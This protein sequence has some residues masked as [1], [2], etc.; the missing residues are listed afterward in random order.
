[1]K[2]KLF[3]ITLLCLA[4]IYCVWLGYNQMFPKVVQTFPKY[5]TNYENESQLFEKADAVVKIKA[6]GE[7]REII[8]GIDSISKIPIFGYTISKVEIMEVYKSTELEKKQTIDFFEPYFSYTR[9]ITGEKFIVPTGNYK[10]L[11]KGKIYILYIHKYDRDDPKR[12][13]LYEPIQAEYG[14]YRINEKFNESIDNSSFTVDD[15]DIYR[16]NSGYEKLFREIMK[17]YK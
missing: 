3:I 2:K 5:A 15:Y 12:F 6:L 11:V 10:P 1:M 8:D 9:P 7:S 13:G 16:N 17:K 4:V 14:K